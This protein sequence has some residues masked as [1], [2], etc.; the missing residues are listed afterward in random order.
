M[1]SVVFEAEMAGP[2]KKHEKLAHGIYFCVLRRSSVLLRDVQ[3]LT[4][5]EAHIYGGLN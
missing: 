4:L 3:R 2:L 5:L 1:S